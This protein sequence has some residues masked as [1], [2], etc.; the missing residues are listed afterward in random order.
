MYLPIVIPLD[1]STFA[2]GPGPH[3]IL[4]TDRAEVE[5]AV[6][7][8]AGALSPS[9]RTSIQWQF[10]FGNMLHWKPVDDQVEAMY[11]SGI[12]HAFTTMNPAV[13][14]RMW[15]SSAHEAAERFL[16]VREGAV[17]LL[18]EDDASLFHS[19][20]EV[21]IQHVSEILRTTGLW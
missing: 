17:H 15:F 9:V 21:G 2:W 11:E 18:D 14:D 16:F 20:Y 4:G 13:L 6:N 19:S 12:P 7:R 8:L 10:D 5:R 1:P 3:A